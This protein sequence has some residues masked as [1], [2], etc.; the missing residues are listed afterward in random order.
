VQPRCNGRKLPITLGQVGT[1]P[2]TGPAHAPGARD[3]ATAAGAAKTR[4]SPSVGT[5]NPPGLSDALNRVATAINGGKSRARG[6]HGKLL[7]NRRRRREK[8]SLLLLSIS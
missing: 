7:S 2:F 6:G 5:G 4:T 3:L 8:R 1:L